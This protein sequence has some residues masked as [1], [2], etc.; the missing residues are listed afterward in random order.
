MDLAA[1]NTIYTPEAYIRLEESGQIRHEYI[2]GNLIEMS[3]TSREHHK[4][5]K[6]ILALL[7]S[8]LTIQNYE[9]YLENMKVAIPDENQYY[10]PDILVTKEAE[11]DQNRNVQYQLEMRATVLSKIHRTKNF[12]ENLYNTVK[13]LHWNIFYW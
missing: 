2:N 8:L 3:G 9:V 6:K 13:F 11:T 4:M 1:A 12:I 5:C 10:Y 7:E